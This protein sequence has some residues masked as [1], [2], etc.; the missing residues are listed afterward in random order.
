VSTPASAFASEFLSQFSSP[1][2]AAFVEALDLDP[3]LARLADSLAEAEQDLQ[4]ASVELN[5]VSDSTNPAA[6]TLRLAD[7]DQA[8]MALAD[9]HAQY[10]R[11]LLATFSTRF[12]QLFSA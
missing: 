5:R 6:H 3:P 2:R 1:D 10:R 9:L 4:L 7:Y 11:T 8:K 12:P